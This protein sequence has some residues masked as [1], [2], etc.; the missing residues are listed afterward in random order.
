M[1]GIVGLAEKTCGSDLAAVLGDMLARMRHHPW[2]AEGRH[3][4]EA[5]GVAFGRMALGFTDGATQPAAN[6]D[7]SV[8]ATLD[9]EVYDHDEH[10]QTLTAAGHV[11]HGHGPAE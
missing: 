3:V 2:Y 11:F 10:R 4:D 7:P 5:A 8:L 6:E 9:G 1:P